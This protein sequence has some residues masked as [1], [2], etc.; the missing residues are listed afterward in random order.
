MAAKSAIPPLVGFINLLFLCHHAYSYPIIAEIHAGLD[1]KCFTYTIPEHDDAHMVVVA[2]PHMESVDVEEYY[3]DAIHS[4]SEHGG[5]KMLGEMPEM[6]PEVE[7]ELTD[8]KGSSGLLLDFLL[9][10]RL[11]RPRKLQYHVPFIIR[12]LK[13]LVF[14]EQRMNLALEGISICFDGQQMDND[15][16]VIFDVVRVS[17]ES[18]EG[19]RKKLEKKISQK[20]DLT[21]I[22]DNLKQSIQTAS[23][24]LSEMGTVSR[25]EFLMRQ[26]TNKR[27]RGVA[28]FSYLSVLVL[29]GTSWVQITYL[30]GYFRKKKLM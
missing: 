26:G 9:E 20:E 8:N 29:L 15:V 25:R 30:K 5:R 11:E 4:L 7:K 1:P 17:D 3:V 27:N 22:Q 28:Y 21:P 23:N 16:V 19:I 6:P 18:H 24:V 10:K 13:H 12:N 14:R 2:I